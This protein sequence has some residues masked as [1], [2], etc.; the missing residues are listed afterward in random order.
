VGGVLSLMIA[1]LAIQI[2]VVHAWGVE[3]RSR[4]LEEL[5]AEPDRSGSSPRAAEA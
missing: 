3:P 5:E 4:A 2:L 1:L